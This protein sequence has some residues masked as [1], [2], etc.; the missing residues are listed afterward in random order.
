M[1]ITPY[2]LYEDAGA[3][4]GWLKRAFGTRTVGRPMK[5]ADG[6]VRHANLALDGNELMLGGPAAGYKNPKNS[7]GATLLLYIDVP[8]VQKAF[9]RAVKA[10]ATVIESPRPT[11]YGAL[12]CAVADPEGHQW[13]FAQPL[14][15]RKKKA[16]T[17]TA[18]KRR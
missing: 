17:R 2:L 10:G 7:G 9:D 4:I 12:R 13:W 15:K 11:P 16:K 14:P 1:A 3:A 5:D 6:I 8:D 18:R